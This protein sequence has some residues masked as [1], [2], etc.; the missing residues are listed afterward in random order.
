[1][2]RNILLVGLGGGVGSIIR[3]LSSV[4]TAKF[5]SSVFPLATFV[6]NIIGCLLIGL[7]IG[8][9]NNHFSLDNNLKLLLITGFC[10]GYTTFSTFA[11]ENLVLFQS[12]NLFILAIY[13]ITSVLFG[14]L[15]VGI[16]VYLSVY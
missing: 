9:I 16:G 12:N 13:T 5:Y 1:M 6:V 10:G 7:F 4:Y 15:A 2:I 11:L 8:V 14:I 3:Y